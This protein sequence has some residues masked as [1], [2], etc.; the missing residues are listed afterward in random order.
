MCASAGSPKGHT[1]A[2]HRPGCA[3]WDCTGRQAPRL[4]LHDLLAERPLLVVELCQSQLRKPGLLASGGRT[5]RVRGDP[6]EGYGGRQAGGGG[7]HLAHRFPPW[8]VSSSAN[9]SKK[10]GAQAT[11]AEATV[12]SRDRAFDVPQDRHDGLRRGRQGLP[13]YLRTLASN[14]H[15]S[16]ASQRSN[17]GPGLVA[18]V[19]CRA[20]R[21]AS[22]R[23]VGVDARPAT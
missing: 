13:F 7:Q 8:F 5:G 4:S 3:T 2:A 20:A 22:G 15:K 6:T 17:A 11:G 1:C 12:R 23:R 19:T 16:G 21:M 10:C 18:A 14:L 9:L